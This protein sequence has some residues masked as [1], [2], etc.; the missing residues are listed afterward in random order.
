MSINSTRE[1][2][3][4]ELF[5]LASKFESDPV[6]AE[7]ISQAI[8]KHVENC[9]G[10]LF[11]SDQKQMAKRKLLIAVCEKLKET[12]VL[13]N[14][15]VDVIDGILK[16]MAPKVFASLSN[17]QRNRLIYCPNPELTEQAPAASEPKLIED[18]RTSIFDP[19]LGQHKYNGSVRND[20]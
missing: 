18:H 4:N 9:L 19:T 7:F 12:C 1:T 10:A 6:N 8:H 5:H 14:N 17:Q 20:R 13:R 15:A 16:T 2:C 3:T 11:S